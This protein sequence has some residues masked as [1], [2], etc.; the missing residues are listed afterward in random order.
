M[1]ALAAAIV[2][3]ATQ[4][5][6]ETYFVQGAGVVACARADDLAR[7]TSCALLAPNAAVAWDGKR[8]DGFAPRYLGGD[9]ARVEIAGRARFVYAN[10]LSTRPWRDP[11]RREFTAGAG[12]IACRSPAKFEDAFYAASRGD[13]A[14]LRE[15]GCMTIPEGTAATRLAPAVAADESAWRM[16]VRFAQSAP[17]DLWMIPSALH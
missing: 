3:V 15:A 5:S 14:L 11:L 7:K 6:A 1:R 12:A 13:A 16:R 8:I 2:L 4:A 10:F 17:Q 9:V